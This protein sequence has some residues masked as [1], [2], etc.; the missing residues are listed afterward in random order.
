MQMERSTLKRLYPQGTFIKETLQHII[1]ECDL[2]P[3]P[4]S[5]T[6]R[7][8]IDYKANQRPEVF[9]VSPKPLL[10]YKDTQNLEHVYST[11]EQKLCLYHPTFD[12][13]NFSMPLVRTIIP[14]TAEWL[15]SYEI[16]VVTGGWE[17]GGIHPA[18]VQP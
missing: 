5:Q 9:V 4:L 12:K 7:I 13:W 1:W 11:K 16:W 2:L 6:Y 3:T 14:W 8:R 15:M 18:K 10:R 17:G